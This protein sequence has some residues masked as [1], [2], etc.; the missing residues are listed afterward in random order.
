ML[1]APVLQNVEALHRLPEH[2]SRALVT[3]TGSTKRAILE[4]AA[5]LPPALPFIG[6]HPLAGAAAGGVEAAR[7]DLFDDRPWLLTPP[8]SASAAVAGGAERVR[9]GGPRRAAA[10]RRSTSTT[11]CWRTSAIFLNSP[12]AR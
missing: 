1:A 9:Q 6:G 11:G 10:D 7:P 5:G 2:A 4:A 12:S 8:P 3:D